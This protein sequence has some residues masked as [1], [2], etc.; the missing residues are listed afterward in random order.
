MISSDESAERPHQP[1]SVQSVQDEW[2]EHIL[3]PRGT[4]VNADLDDLAPALYVS[5]DDP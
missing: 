5:I 3:I 1:L 4:V 2:S